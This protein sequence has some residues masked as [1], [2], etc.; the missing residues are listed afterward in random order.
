V[1]F[2]GGHGQAGVFARIANVLNHNGRVP[3][4]TNAR[5]FSAFLGSQPAELCDRRIHIS[6]SVPAEPNLPHLAAAILQ[7]SG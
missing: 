6:A 2:G 7:R 4:G 5:A 1:L 3:T